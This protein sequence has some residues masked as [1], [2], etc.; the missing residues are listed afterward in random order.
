MNSYQI[1]NK[2]RKMKCDQVTGSCQNLSW[3]EYQLKDYGDH[4]NDGVGG[5]EDLTTITISTQVGH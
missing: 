4:D 2:I 1:I 5:D 3:S